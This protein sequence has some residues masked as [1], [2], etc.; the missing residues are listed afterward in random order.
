M[1]CKPLFVGTF[2]DIETMTSNVSLLTQRMSAGVN[3]ADIYAGWRF[4]WVFKA[5]KNNGVCA[6]N[7]P[8]HRQAFSHLGKSGLP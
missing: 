4:A 8:E 5:G 1:V 6:L 3:A 7:L 2:S